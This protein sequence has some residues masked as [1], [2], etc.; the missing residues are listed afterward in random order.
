MKGGKRL[1]SGRKKCSEPMVGL[2]IKLEPS[3]LVQL[4]ELYGKKLSAKVRETI[5][6]Y[7]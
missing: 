2:Q 4:R 5:N 1:G 6:Q 7:L 3:K